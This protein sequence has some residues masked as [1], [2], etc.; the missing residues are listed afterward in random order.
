M[1]VEVETCRCIGVLEKVLAG[2]MRAIWEMEAEGKIDAVTALHRSRPY[3]RMGNI[4]GE[5]AEMEGCR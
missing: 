5:I 2:K 1:V 4:L 3:E